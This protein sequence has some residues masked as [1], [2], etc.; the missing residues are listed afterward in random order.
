M[1]LGNK[2]DFEKC[3]DP[4]NID[5]FRVGSYDL[6]IDKII[7]N[8]GKH[9]TSL[10]LKPQG[11]AFVIFK[12]RLVLPKNIIGFAHV[13]TSYTQ[14]A[15]LSTNIGIVDPSY[16][17]SVST[18][19]INFG[20]NSYYL[21]KG[22]KALR[23][24]L[25]KIDETEN[26][27]SIVQNKEIQNEKFQYLLQ[28]K[29]NINKLDDKFLSLSLL[30]SEIEKEVK[31]EIFS[32]IRNYVGFITMSALILSFVI[33]TINLIKESNKDGRKIYAEESSVSRLTNKID[34][35]ER[36]ILNEKSKTLKIDSNIINVN[37]KNE[38]IR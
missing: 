37:I 26:L 2:E 36:I 11:V 12:E 29:E 4:F 7:D 13:K 35:L 3:I 25:N 10:N 31:K 19:L 16:N 14:N 1:N 15:I 20:K 27:A 22:D 30:K 8:S 28:R 9:L 21:S 38:N 18:L 23:L 34:S 32:T 5:N 24:T 6:T 33:M 17:G